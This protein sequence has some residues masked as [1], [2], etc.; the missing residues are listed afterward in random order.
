MNTDSLHSKHRPKTLNEVIGQPDIVKRLTKILSEGRTHTFL[1]TGPA[2]TGKTTLARIIANVV[3][4]GKGTAANREEI[5]AATHTGAESVR[6]ITAR[7]AYRAIGES[8]IKVIIIDEAHRLSGTAWDAL[9]KAT[10]EPPS[11]VYWVFCSTNP[12]KIP[13]TMQTRCLKFELRPVSEDDLYKLLKKVVSAEKFDVDDSI[14]EIIIDESGGSPRQALVY[15]EACLYCESA[16]EARRIMRS[17][18]QS[19]EVVDLCRFII[20]PQGGWVQAMKLIKGLGDIEA[21]GV[22]INVVNYLG[23]TLLKTS[24]VGAAK[25]LLFL[26]ECFGE[27]YRSSEKMAPLLRSVGL[28]LGMDHDPN[29]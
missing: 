23:A 6:A 27:E 4:N 7:S 19:K 24:D 25:H 13:K 5:D 21:E 29:T 15:L 14:L 20:R 10:E 9:L 11:H 3:T 18:S 8:P 22:R 26:L 28:A 12:G 1:F 2:G 17:A 16:A